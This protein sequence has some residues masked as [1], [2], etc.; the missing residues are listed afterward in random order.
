MTLSFGAEKRKDPVSLSIKFVHEVMDLN[1]TECSIRIVHV[2]GSSVN[3][4]GRSKL[5]A[6]R[7]FEWHC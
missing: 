4:G 7:R 5:G 1:A 2:E 6:L 3:G